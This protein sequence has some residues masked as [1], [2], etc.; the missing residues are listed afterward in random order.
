MLKIISASLLLMAVTSVNVQACNIKGGKDCATT[1]GHKA[2]HK[3]KKG[4]VAPAGNVG[5][6]SHTKAPV[7]LGRASSGVVASVTPRQAEHNYFARLSSGDFRAV[8]PR[9]VSSQT[10]T[11]P[12]GSLTQHALD[13]GFIDVR[14]VTPGMVVQSTP[15]P[16]QQAT[17]YLVPAPVKAPA[18]I[19]AQPPA[20]GTTIGLTQVVY[21]GGDGSFHSLAQIAAMQGYLVNP[22]GTLTRAGQNAGFNIQV[23]PASGVK[24]VWNVNGRQVVLTQPQF[25]R[26]YA[27]GGIRTD[28]TLTQAS[29]NNGLGL[30]VQRIPG[31]V[32][33]KTQTPTMQPPGK[34]PV[35]IPQQAP[36]VVQTPGL[37]P[38]LLA[39]GQVPGA[40]P[41]QAPSVVQTPGLTPSQLAPGQVPGATPQQAP[42]VVQTPG[43]TPSQLAPGQVPGATPQQAPTVVQ[44]PGLT[45]S[46]L[47]PGQV[48][49]AIPQQVPNMVQTPGQAPSQLVSVQ[50]PI[51]AGHIENSDAYKHV[52]SAVEVY[53][54]LHGASYHYEDAMS[55][56][57]PGFHF[58]VVGFKQPVN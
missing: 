35:A 46:L 18:Q 27:H 2:D 3:V 10:L 42:S 37:T 30:I 48:P 5:K 13:V 24:Y 9:I 54:P 34:I 15:T 44:T 8:S 14:V 26:L 22:D 25:Q 50:S 56:G 20:A 11:N 16:S 49:G 38:S 19:S 51:L 32:P 6:K 23:A 1:A 45:P 53:H 39:P 58:V 47:A 40:I 52:N 55:Y 21:K 43:L 33:S 36:S 57:D 28:G 41:Q 29:I 17:P 4:K 12:D 31:L 7:A